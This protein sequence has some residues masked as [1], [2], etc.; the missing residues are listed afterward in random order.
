MASLAAPPAATAAEP[1]PTGIVELLT[2]LQQLYREAEAAGETYNAAEEELKEQAARTAELTGDLARTRDA[3]ARSRA[4]AGHL[5]RAQYQ[6][7]TDLSLS[8]RLLFARDADRALEQGQVFRRVAREQAAAVARLASGEKRADALATASRRA[9]DRQQT[10]IARREAARDTARSRLDQAEK[11]LAG[12]SPD[13]LAELAALESSRTQDAQS[14]LLAGGV[15]GG[16]ERLP[17]P[18]GGEALDYAMAQLGK[19]YAAGAE[20]PEAFDGSGLASRAWSEAGRTVPRTS[21]EQWRV[22]PRVPLRSLRPG[23]LVLYFPEATHVALYL[24]RGLV[25][26]APHPGGRVR[27][28]PLAAHPVLGA[29]R[30]DAG[31]RSL[32]SYSPPE[33]PP[34]AAALLDAQAEAG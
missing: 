6:G 25:V 10:L 22:L 18:L 13:Q 15:L 28:A 24:G 2:K 29:V 12:L 3:L 32:G 11:V 31:V 17:S 23:D 14:A 34:E 27:V 5:A 7:R 26:H 1:A 9:L 8:L 33:L 30:P 4:V 19:P 16:G 21:G 20:G